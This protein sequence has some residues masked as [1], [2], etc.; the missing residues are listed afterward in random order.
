[1]LVF[2]RAWPACVRDWST[3]QKASNPPSPTD[4]KSVP[5]IGRLPL[6]IITRPPRTL[7]GFETVRPT[8]AGQV[9]ADLQLIV[10]DF[11]DSHQLPAGNGANAGK[12]PCAVNG[13]GA[14]TGIDLDNPE[15]REVAVVFDPVFVNSEFPAVF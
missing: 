1:M 9:V 7:V 5:H 10:G 12:R 11:I 13:L 8:V 14:P 15:L 6:E 4:C 3:M 2:I